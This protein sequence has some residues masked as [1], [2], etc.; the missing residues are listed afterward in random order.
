M[1][2]FLKYL[3]VGVLCFSLFPV[4]TGAAAGATVAAPAQA[5][6]VVS[7]SSP[8]ANNA[9]PEI[10]VYVNGKLLAL[11]VA[12]MIYDDRTMVPV[13][14]IT[15]AV[16]CDV[17]WFEDEMRVVIYTP[18][19][20]DPFM[21]MRIDDANV[22]IT[23]HDYSKDPVVVWNENAMVDVRPMM[24]NGRTF[25]PLRFVAE[26]MGFA[27]E[28]DEAEQA[29]RISSPDDAA[30]KRKL[31]G[32]WHAMN[33]VGAGFDERYAFRAN[34]SFVYASSATRL[35]REAFRLGTWDIVG[36]R[37]V[38][39]VY[40]KIMKE[41]GYIDDFDGQQ[42]LSDVDYALRPVADPKT[43]SLS[44][45]LQGADPETGR[46]T[47]DIN[48]QPFYNFSNQPNLLSDYDEIF[49]RI[50]WFDPGAGGGG[51][52]RIADEIN[53]EMSSGRIQPFAGGVI[54]KACFYHDGMG[55][56]ITYYYVEISAG[57]YV[58]ITKQ[59]MAPPAPIEIQVYSTTYNLN[60]YAGR[61]IEFWGEGFEAETIH[62]RRDYV[63]NIDII[64]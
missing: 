44:I 34:G 18:E 41:N 17:A 6:Q 31:T 40:A 14:A 52:I 30:L 1:H 55:E 42:Y 10:K 22:N 21:E 47:I 49:G 54:Q 3:L 56:W 13:R 63:L 46:D 16:G 4:P 36:G 28:W 23:M 24:Y 26:W 58:Y 61:Y 35:N 11:D 51:A 60:E 12:P 37:I 5:V 2:A 7:V 19:H 20:R 15:E 45:A 25:L 48:Y 57:Q 62:H 38:F 59:D 27:V 50:G 8:R 64:K 9:E 32:Q 53:Y 29:V 43:E 39:R 33:F